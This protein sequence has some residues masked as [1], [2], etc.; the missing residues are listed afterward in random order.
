[1]DIRSNGTGGTQRVTVSVN[2]MVHSKNGFANIFTSA[3]P[4][5]GKLWV[6]M[7]GNNVGDA[8]E[9]ANNDY[10]VRVSSGLT[11]GDG[12]R[13]CAHISGNTIGSGY[14]SVANGGA[15]RLTNNFTS[16]FLTIPGYGGTVTD[17]AAAAAY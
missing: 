3:S 13:A 8:D 17:T 10:A 5:F 12:T 14:A 1:M 4:D 2:T 7:T 16:S 6:N 15:I 9:P 11:A